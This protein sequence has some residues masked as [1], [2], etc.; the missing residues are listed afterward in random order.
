[1]QDDAAQRRSESGSDWDTANKAN[2]DSRA[3]V[4]WDGGR[5]YYDL[6]A[7]RAGGSSLRH[8]ERE[9]AGD[10][11]GQRI[12]HLMC[13]IGL[14]SVSWARLGA[15]VTAVDSSTVAIDFARR[16][17]DDCNVRVAFH[18]TDILDLP[19]ACAGP[20]SLIVMTYGV[21]AWL[22]EL[23]PVAAL[24]AERLAP[25]GKFLLVDGH[26]MTNLWPP[27]VGEVDLQFCN[28]GYFA[29]ET[30]ERR[31]CAHS[32]GGAGVLA[33]P[34]SYQWSH[35]VGE[36]VQAVANAGLRL[37]VLREEPFGFYQRYP[38]MSAR[39]DGYWAPPVGLEGLPFL[40]AL[41]AE[42]S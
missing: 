40:L 41:M 24:V 10:V 4:H 5:S 2:W 26:P 25:D 8:I 15:R 29:S 31:E 34:T 22:K 21:L 42:R 28:R 17:A 38:D 35:S 37:T 39:Q 16:L 20:F 3:R 9:L 19:E 32:Y 6:K 18:A 7:L 27:K 30:P 14:D 12:L 36:I 13:H 23:G 11:A 1:M 33:S